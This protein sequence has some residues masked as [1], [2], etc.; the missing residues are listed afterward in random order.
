MHARVLDIAPEQY[1]ADPCAT[2]SLSA[3]IAKLLVD[4]S[5]RH[6]WAAHP[7]LGGLA[8]ESSDS[9]DS[10]TLIHRLLLGAGADLAVI[11][12]ADYRTNA[13][14]AA[15]EEAR[16]AGKLPVLAGK[17]AE[18]NAKAEKLRE[19]L[20]AFGVDLNARSEVPIEWHEYA[21]TGEPVLCRA[22]LDHVDFERGQIWDLKTITCAHPDACARAMV[23]Y[24]YDLQEAAYRSALRHLCPE[25]SGREDFTFL[26]LELHPP[27]CVLPVRS[28]GQFRAMG[29]ARW[30][31]ALGLWKSCLAS[32]HWPGYA[33]DAV[34]LSPPNW[35]LAKAMSEGIDVGDEEGGPHDARL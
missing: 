33:A 6:A 21:G 4:R 35:A 15:R 27:H 5:P 30:Q 25:W 22:M 1:H 18:A 34:R 31:R 14:K 8:R 12:A 20:R 7:R 2:P 16:A 28:D 10:G 29:D 19:Q 17:L 11:D 26:F 32:N 13:A 23:A 9:M 3:S 24:G